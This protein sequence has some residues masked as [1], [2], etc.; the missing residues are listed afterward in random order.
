MTTP[1]KTKKF[2]RNIED[3]TCSKCGFFV[4]GNGYTN[5]CPKCL[6]SKHVDINPG[7]RKSDCLGAMEPIGVEVKAGEYVITHQCIKCGFVRKNKTT[8]DDDFNLL[9]NL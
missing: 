5:H 2:K 9:L 8:K 6:W 3:F 4:A 7:D 1:I